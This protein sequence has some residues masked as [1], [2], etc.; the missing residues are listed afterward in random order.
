MIIFPITFLFVVI[1]I[2]Y[3]YMLQMTELYKQQLGFS[4]MMP[5][6]MSLEMGSDKGAFHETMATTGEYV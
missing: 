5:E 4:A 3:I 2:C 6:G 1:A